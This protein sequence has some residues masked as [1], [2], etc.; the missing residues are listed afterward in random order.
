MAL[1]DGADDEVDDVVVYL[2][3]GSTD[4]GGGSVDEESI[5]LHV[6]ELGTVCAGV[7]LELLLLLRVASKGAGEGVD[8]EVKNSAE[9][10]VVGCFAVGI[11]R[12]GAGLECGR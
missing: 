3:G 9:G 5:D 8:G 1:H 11:L 4:L 10:E 2:A 12:S 6:T 7:V